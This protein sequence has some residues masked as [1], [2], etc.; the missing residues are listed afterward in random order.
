MKSIVIYFSQTGNTE[1]V[2]CAIQA[3][4]KQATGRCDIAKMKDVNPKQLYEYDLIGMGSAVFGGQ[5]GSLAILLNDLR[6]V[7]GKHAFLFCT[8]G[9]VLKGGDFFPSAYKR[10]K[11]S[12]LIIIGTGDWY[13]DC[14]LLHM[15][16]PYPTA[17]HP[18]EIDLKEA[19]EFGREMVMRSWRI[20]AGEIGLIPPEPTAPELPRPPQT[21]NEQQSG[22]VHSFS[23]KL[24]F[25]KE[26]CLFPKCRLC[27]ENCPVAGIDLSVNPPILAQP[28]LSCEWCARICPTGALDMDEWVRGMAAATSN[29]FS[30]F[31]NNLKKAE[32]EGLFRRLEQGKN[33]DE[34]YSNPDNF[35]FKMNKNHPQW[36][37][38]RG[39]P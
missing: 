18:D 7:G 14:Y 27:M 35:G 3:G 30:E 32:E 11:K 9:T 16:E 17:G 10:V 4:I 37:I 34:Y 25:Y 1:K 23:K 22:N 13:G 38:G 36:I 39:A 2:A 15:P 5:L 12:G 26:K 31:L 24:K 28:C 21:N 8:H 19:E 20:T 6:F 33:P 29:V